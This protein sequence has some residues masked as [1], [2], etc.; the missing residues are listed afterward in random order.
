M[1]NSLPNYCCNNNTDSNINQ[2]KSNQDENINKLI[3]GKMTLN[4]LLY[5]YDY[6]NIRVSLVKTKDLQEFFNSKSLLKV[7]DKKEINNYYD[8]ILLTNFLDINETT[9]SIMEFIQNT[10]KESL[11]EIQKSDKNSNSINYYIENIQFNNIN[12]ND[13]IETSKNFYELIMNNIK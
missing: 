11:K 2:S 3:Y 6:K 4:N 9:F 12:N 7:L 5:H 1:G 13:R 8:K 10:N